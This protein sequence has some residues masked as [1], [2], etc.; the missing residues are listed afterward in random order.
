MQ[1]LKEVNPDAIALEESNAL[2]LAII[3]SGRLQ[4]Q[5]SNFYV[6]SSSIAQCEEMLCE[7]YMVHGYRFWAGQAQLVYPLA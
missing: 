2:A 3:P 4:H 7:Q 1:G 5:Y 6:V